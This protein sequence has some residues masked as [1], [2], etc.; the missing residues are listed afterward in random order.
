MIDAAVR[1]VKSVLLFKSKTN[2]WNTLVGVAGTLAIV[3]PAVQ[4][5]VGGNA[6]IVG[7]LAIVG[8]VVQAVLREKT[9]EALSTKVG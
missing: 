1:F 7:I 8:A 6:K 4:T 9:T 3:L 2:V 5:W